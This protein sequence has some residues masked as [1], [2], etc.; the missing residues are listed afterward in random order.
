MCPD[1]SEFVLTGI[2][3]WEASL[4]SVFFN[5][6]EGK[7][8]P[9]GKFFSDPEGKFSGN[10]PSGA[11]WAEQFSSSDT[12]IL[13]TMFNSESFLCSRLLSEGTKMNNSNE[14]NSKFS[15][16]RLAAP[17]RVLNPLMLLS[18]HRFGEGEVIRPKGG[19]FFEVKH[20]PSGE[21]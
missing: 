7:F 18:D 16:G 13:F 21:K 20:L 3:S 5:P 12:N 11:V 6:L 15:R 17:P 14:K 10:L 4:T 2:F 19:H 8:L 9:S 1:P